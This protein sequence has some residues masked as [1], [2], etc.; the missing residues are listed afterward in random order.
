MVVSGVPHF[1]RFFRAAASLD[2]DKDDLKRHVGFV[3]QKI[4][5]LLQVANANAR[6]NGRDIVEPHD[7]PITK[8]LQESIHRFERMDTDVGLVPLLDD[9][10][11]R[12]PA[13]TICSEETEAR[14]PQVAGG[15]G[16]AVAQL[17]KVFD[18]QLKNPS[19]EHWERAFRTFD[20]LL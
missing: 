8:G 6:A 17:F 13:D 4:Y 9:L 20:L 5:D 2:V 3:S 1:E 19:S 7:L 10:V 15:L 11:T 14:L 12:R 18:P 16:L